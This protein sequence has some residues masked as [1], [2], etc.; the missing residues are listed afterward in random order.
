[1]A[2]SQETPLSSALPKNGLAG[3]YQVLEMPSLYLFANRHYTLQLDFYF[4]TITAVYLMVGSILCFLVTVYSRY[5]LHR[6]GGYKRFFNTILFFFLGYNVVIFSGNFETMFIGWEILGISSFLLIAF[7]RNITFSRLNGYRPVSEHLQQ[8]SGIGIFTSLLILVAAAAKSA[9]LPF[10]SWLPQA[11]KGPTP[12]SVIFYG[13]LSGHIGAFLL[14]RTYTFWEH[15]PTVRLVI[16]G[17]G[18]ATALVASGIARVQS[19]I[20]SQIARV[21]PGPHNKTYHEIAY[22]SSWA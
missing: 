14:L 22:R 13:S 4:G 12:S 11:L 18:L 9:Q 5:Y 10:S 2:V 15:Q 19:S 17:L 16:I 20:K 7:Y 8:H 1:M 6:E 3:G 21:F